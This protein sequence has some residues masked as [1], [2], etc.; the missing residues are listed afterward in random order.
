MAEID[1]EQIIN[2]VCANPTAISA[3]DQITI[4]NDSILSG[5]VWAQK[6]DGALDAAMTLKRITDPRLRGRGSYGEYAFKPLSEI[7]K[8]V[9]RY[10]PNSGQPL[11]DEDH[12]GQLDD[13]ELILVHQVIK[14][15]VHTDIYAV[16]QD[17]L[18]GKLQRYSAVKRDIDEAK[19]KNPGQYALYVAEIHQPSFSGGARQPTNEPQGGMGGTFKDELNRCFGLNDLRD[20]CFQLGV[21]DEDI[22]GETKGMFMLNMIGYFQRRNRFAELQTSAQRMRPNMR[23][24]A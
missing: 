6:A 9:V 15:R 8:A 11:L 7:V 18:D 16:V 22:G 1:Y 23:V 19:A 14:R 20:L 12:G 10:M 24:T 3:N 5:S 13:D 2:R 4:T 21:N 17:I